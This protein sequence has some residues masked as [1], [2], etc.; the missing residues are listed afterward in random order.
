LLGN[1]TG[2]SRLR[3]GLP[4]DW[5]VGDKTGSGANGTTNDVAILWPP[6]R[7]PLLVAAYLTGSKLDSAGRDAI[8]ASLARALSA[9]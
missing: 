9:S 3:A 6:G 4:K 7:A 1:T 5:R 8:H 2:N